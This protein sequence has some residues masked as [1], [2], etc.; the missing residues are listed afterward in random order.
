LG[1]WPSLIPIVVGV[2]DNQLTMINQND[3]LT[4]QVKAEKENKP[5]EL[6]PYKTIFHL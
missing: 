6:K 4:L 2:L 1:F 5:Y 3:K